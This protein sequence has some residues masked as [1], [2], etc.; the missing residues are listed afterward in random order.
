MASR[1][2][3]LFPQS[4]FLCLTSF[5]DSYEWLLVV[6]TNRPRFRQLPCLKGSKMLRHTQG[7]RGHKTMT[8]GIQS[9]NSRSGKPSR[10]CTSIMHVRLI[11]RRGGTGISLVTY[12]RIGVT[13]SLS[14][15]H[16][17]C[18]LSAKWSRLSQSTHPIRISAQ[19]SPNRQLCPLSSLAYSRSANF[20]MPMQPLPSVHRIAVDVS[21]T[22]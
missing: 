22:T 4:L 19:V 15:Q 18:C 20:V 7:R 17:L 8:L 16:W 1:L 9:Q 6:V 10:H 2:S 3:Q 12:C 14:N 13:G 5:L 11:F 21:T